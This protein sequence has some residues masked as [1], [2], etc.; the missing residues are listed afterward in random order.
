PAHRFPL[1]RST[2]IAFAARFYRDQLQPRC[3]PGFG[4]VAKS[5]TAEAGSYQAICSAFS[6]HRFP[7]IAPRIDPHRL[8]REVLQE[9]ASALMLLAPVVPRRASR[10]KPV[11]TK[12]ST[13]RF[14]LIASRSPP[15]NKLNAISNTAP[16]LIA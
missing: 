13:H 10:L 1:R 9:P 7:F 2:R 16:T 6:V 3:V 11:P 4:R 8:R 14:P 12:A 15:A 5:I